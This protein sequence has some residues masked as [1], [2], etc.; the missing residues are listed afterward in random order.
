MCRYFD[1]SFNVLLYSCLM[2]LVAT[3]SL[4]HRSFFVNTYKAA[5]K[6]FFIIHRHSRWFCLYK[7]NSRRVTLREFIVWVCKK[8]FSNSGS[9]SFFKF[10]D[11]LCSFVFSNS[12]FDCAKFF[13]KT[14][15][16]NKT[17]T[18]K[19]TNNFDNSDF[20]SAEIF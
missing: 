3:S 7:Q 9:A 18:C 4:A 19:F 5:A 16:F 10:F 12:F 2:R 15:S 13:N 20:V 8:L 6:A 11:H 14:L 1:F 17:K